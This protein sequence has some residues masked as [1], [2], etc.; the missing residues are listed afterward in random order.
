MPS[1]FLN[2]VLIQWILSAVV[3]TT[4]ISVSSSRGD[5]STCQEKE[6]TPC[7]SLEK[8]N[9]LLKVYGHGVTLLIQENATLHTV[10]EVVNSTEIHIAGNSSAAEIT[11]INCTSGNAGFVIDGVSNFSFSNISVVN[12]TAAYTGITSQNFALLVH[13]STNVAIR[14]ASFRQC[15]CTAVLFLD[16]YHKVTIERSTFTDNH[17]PGKRKNYRSRLSNP[18]ALSI[19]Q[20]GTENISVHYNI[21]TSIFH[22]N[23]VP[24]TSN[25]AYVNNSAMFRYRGYG[26][27]V[28]IEFGGYTRGSVATIYNTNFTYNTGT[29]GGGIYAYY[30]HSASENRIIILNCLFLGNNADLSGGGVNIGFY[31]P[32]SLQN[33]FLL[34]ACR[35]V[36]NSALYGGGMSIF[37]SYG[38]K[39]LEHS[40]NLHFANNTFEDNRA[41]LS[42]AVDI[43][44]LLDEAQAVEGYLPLPEFSNCSF[45]HNAIIDSSKNKRTTHV[46]S[47]V[48]SIKR[49]KVIF[50][51]NTYFVRNKYSALLI[52][53]GMAEFNSHSRVKFFN[54]LGH[55]GGAVLM[56]SFSTIL[57]NPYSFFNF[58]RNRAL[59]SGGAIYYSTSDQHNFLSS[60]TDC[61]IRN[62]AVSDFALI[63]TTQVVFEGNEAFRN[64]LSV[65]S[66]SFDSCLQRCKKI[67]KARSF[68]K[69]EINVFKCSG[70]FT[71]D[72]ASPE[73]KLWP[74]TS[75]ARRFNFYGRNS[76]S[77]SYSVYPEYSFKLPFSVVDD[78]QHK[79]K[80]LMRVSNYN[81][82]DN[83]IYVREP[84]TLSNSI[85]PKGIT[86]SSARF[87][88]TVLGKRQI[89]FDF[90]VALRSC[91]PGYYNWKDICKCAVAKHGYHA[92]T[93]CDSFTFS[94]VYKN[95]MWAGYIP[96]NSSKHTD[97]YFAPC[98][99]P[100]CNDSNHQLPSHRRDI[101]KL[102]CAENR[103]GLM[104]GR[105]V[106]SYSTRYHSRNLSCGPS[107]LCHLGMLFYFLSEIIPMVIICVA[108]VV[109]NF[110]FTS[111]AMVSFVFYNQYLNQLTI[112]MGRVFS[113]LRMPYRIFYGL[114]N[115]D[116]FNI[117]QLSF[118]LW[119]KAQILDVIAMKYVTIAIAFGLI[120]CVIAIVHNNMCSRIL[121]TR[122]SARSSV[123]HGLSAFLVIC[124]TQCTKTSFY[125]LKFTQ[126]LGFQGTREN[127]Y[128]YY[129]GLPYF[130]KHHLM[131]VVP[132][133][134]SL[135]F[136][137][138]L[139]PLVLL[140]YPLSLH[141]L[142][143]CGLSEHWV[144]NKTLRLTGINKLK[145]FIDCFQ[146]CYKDRLRFFA[147]LFFV[148]RVV[149]L[150][151][152]SM[153]PDS[154]GF[155]MYSNL[156]LLIIM[157]IHS[158]I[159]PFKERA[160]NT[161]DS[162]ILFNLT[163][164]NGC[165]LIS[166]YLIN[167]LNDPN[168]AMTDVFIILVTA[169][170]LVLL[171]LPMLVFTS[172]LI[173]IG[174]CYIKARNRIRLG[175]EVNDILDHS[176]ERDPVENMFT[177]SSSRIPYGSIK[178]TY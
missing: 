69:S 46:N 115:F 80:P 174:L 153:I 74:L 6:E 133:L 53:S 139:P 39:R 42:A 169:V 59:E 166:K 41:V 47:G 98:A 22:Y 161:L 81:H 150:S 105:C 121:P 140:L 9:A 135:V 110:S 4:T 34:K 146:S 8:A 160:H 30:T 50:G 85:F 112:H 123:V 173:K 75:S 84:Y 118:C 116:F 167:Q 165:V 11:R 27:A 163:F 72:K 117:E 107:D 157:G 68:R 76:K 73:Q 176:T 97:L 36:N 62:S 104:C 5:D 43:Q 151:L 125:I 101:V 37:S 129:G 131:Y 7:K 148:Y 19:V 26:G 15:N 102:I 33:G 164:I 24:I 52:M 60:S 162:L 44:P 124:Y 17:I 156:L 64:G 127:Y 145:P 54:N 67:V 130:G 16:N 120:L 137:T 57:L 21:S 175:I 113:I 77:L 71:L 58:S 87:A 90:N 143:L 171:Y 111:G 25:V 141:L 147:G 177:K 144:V 32:A 138:I 70:I 99:S 48:F 96:E 49:F 134:F 178:D 20:N 38:E 149:I 136:V 119:R 154:F 66:E 126:P 106:H 89:S 45:L 56:Y 82:S 79:V 1:I 92:I 91:P 142:S 18:G 108:T 93:K 29:R 14:G 170:Q 63:N 158:S 12:C 23:F 61:F 28:F 122:R 155:S 100:L 114:F 35:F 128:S 13:S 51:G 159:R 55:N 88:L 95:S 10:F 65:Y 94:A 40:T 172:Y 168:Q 152:Y 109:F 132:A 103:T 86:N 78:F 83:M 31:S 3:A 2:L